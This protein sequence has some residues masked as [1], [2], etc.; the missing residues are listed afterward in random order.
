M[1]V[2]EKTEAGAHNGIDPKLRPVLVVQ[3]LWVAAPFTYGLWKL[4]EKID[5][6]F[7]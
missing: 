4:F 7:T 1:S 6:L 5:D 2:D 3:W